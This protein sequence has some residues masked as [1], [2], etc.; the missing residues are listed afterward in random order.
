M[1]R[2]LYHKEYDYGDEYGLGITEPYSIDV[3]ICISLRYGIV[4]GIKIPNYTCWNKNLFKL[5]AD[6]IH[7]LETEGSIAYFRLK[8]KCMSKGYWKNL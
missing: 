7:Y 3:K 2:T 5:I 4:W 8:E 6:T 1:T